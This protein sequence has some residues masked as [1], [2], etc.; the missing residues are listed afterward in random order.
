MTARGRITLAL[1]PSDQEIR[2]AV[3]MWIGHMASGDYASAV[4][5][6]FDDPPAPEKFRDRVETFCTTLEAARHEVVDTLKRATGREVRAP[7]PAIATPSQRA[8]VVP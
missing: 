4:A 6:V 2:A 8:H 5:A 1:Q 7:S 3:A